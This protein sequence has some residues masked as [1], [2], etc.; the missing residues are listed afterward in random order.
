MK[1]IP[2]ETATDVGSVGKWVGAAAAGALLMYLLDPDR[3]SA[4]RRRA[5]AALREAGARTG[6]S[7][8]QVLHSASDSLG[9]V[10]N[11][12]AD[13]L[14]RGASRVHASAAPMVER[15]Q[16][17]VAQ[18]SV[19]AEHRA[20]RG[21]R[22]AESSAHE[23]SLAPDRSGSYNSYESDRNYESGYRGRMSATPRVA[24]AYDGGFASNHALLGGF[25]GM[26]GLVRRSPLGLLVG[27]AGL[28]L[29]ARGGAGGQQL[30]RLLHWNSTWTGAGYRNKLS[31]DTDD[32]PFT[33]AAGQQGSRYLH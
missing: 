31:T 6:A 21:A 24:G 5:L 14:A 28:A 12:A 23:R 10:T 27:L 7:V 11:S 18:A 26:L 32:L 15:M 17:S 8:G 25:L 4:R 1:P 9:A 33:P 19:R 16:D 20:E 2:T 13:A 3:G 30:S 22:R 29:L